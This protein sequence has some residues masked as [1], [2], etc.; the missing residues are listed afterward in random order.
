MK[1]KVYLFL[2]EPEKYPDFT[3]RQAKAV[4]RKAL[5]DTIQFTSLRAFPTTSSNMKEIGEAVDTGARPMPEKNYLLK[6]ID[7][8][9]ELYVDYFKLG[10]VLWPVYPTL[11]AGNFSELVDKCVEKGLYLYDFWGF[12][13]GSKPCEGIWGE[14]AIPES[15][16][17][18]M[19]EKLGDHFLGYD[20]GEQDGRFIHA[21]AE[22][23]TPTLIGR[24][25]QYRNFQAYF[26]KLND[27]M[28]NHTVT[29]ASL[30]FLHYFAREGNTIM[31]G[32][33]TAQALPSNPMWFSFIRGASKQYGLL[34]YGNA[35]IWN[36]WGYKDYN[37][38]TDQPD[39]SRGSEMG[40]TGG[41]SLSLLR[42]L[43]YNQYMYNCDIL[44]FESGWF[45]TSE[46]KE[47][48]KND[49]KTFIVGKKKYSLTPIG[50]IARSCG[51]F[52]R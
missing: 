48:D 44:G 33:E 17:R 40:R 13:P 21:S 15:T 6:E 39:T 31:L 41:T 27:S 22:A 23:A 25:A 4:T 19:R 35:S 32:A 43:I 38:D 5:G 52:V 26:E 50:S 47:G 28:L 7:E 29:L 30:T 45:I 49:D 37:V 24:E 34:N 18:Y 2:T 9:I 42:R 14:Y 3:R 20:N 51:E 12:V 46:A 16:D 11:F 36:R 8:T 10:R 1:N